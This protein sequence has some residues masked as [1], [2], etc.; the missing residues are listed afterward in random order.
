MQIQDEGFA[1]LVEGTDLTLDDIKKRA[2]ENI[3]IEA[4]EAEPEAVGRD[5]TPQA[6]S[7]STAASNSRRRRARRSI[8]CPAPRSLSGSP[9]PDER[10][11][12]SRQG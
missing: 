12:R 8:A 1:A 2:A 3:Y 10:R 7:S 6:V 11:S 9:R 5:L 4:Q